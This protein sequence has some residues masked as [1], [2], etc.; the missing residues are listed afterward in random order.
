MESEKEKAKTLGRETFISDLQAWHKRIEDRQRELES[1]YQPESIDVGLT[2]IFGNL[3]NVLRT[4]DEYEIES[5]D[6]GLVSVFG[7]FTVIN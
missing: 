3:S 7:E 1:A 5:I 2:G 6:V 4:Y